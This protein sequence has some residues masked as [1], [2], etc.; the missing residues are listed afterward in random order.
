MAKKVWVPEGGDRV[1]RKEGGKV[2]IIAEVFDY[3]EDSW[4][5]ELEGKM[6]NDDEDAN[7]EVYVNEYDEINHYWKEFV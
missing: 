3:S 7:E 6:M 5:V 4:T 2:E 1:R